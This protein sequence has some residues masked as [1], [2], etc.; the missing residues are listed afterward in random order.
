MFY[1]TFNGTIIDTTAE[2]ERKN[3]EDPENGRD[4]RTDGKNA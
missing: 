1:R 2:A 3:N 4:V